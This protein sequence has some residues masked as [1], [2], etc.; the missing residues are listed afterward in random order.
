[1]IT[2]ASARLATATMHASTHRI[3]RLCHVWPGLR[4]RA[5]VWV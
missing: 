3:Q 2:R 5:M 1:M 4:P